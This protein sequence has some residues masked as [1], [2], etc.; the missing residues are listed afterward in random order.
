MGF[1][2]FSDP[3]NDHELCHI[4]RMFVK[5]F[6]PHLTSE[7]SGDFLLL[8]SSLFQKCWTEKSINLSHFRSLKF[9]SGPIDYM[10]CL[11]T[12]FRLVKKKLWTGCPFRGQ[13]SC[14][15]SRQIMLNFILNVALRARKD[16][17]HCP[18]SSQVRCWEKLWLVLS[19]TFRLGWENVG[20]G[21]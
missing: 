3:Q 20:S 6:R 13:I 14:N 8:L 16:W 17:N 7:R 4:L 2:W 9:L 18:R 19:L 1:D 11:L 21:P 5:D 15:K 10:W 12:Q